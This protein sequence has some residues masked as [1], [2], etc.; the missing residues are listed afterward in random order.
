MLAETGQLLQ[1]NDARGRQGVMPNFTCTNPILQTLILDL[2]PRSRG[3]AILEE[4]DRNGNGAF[5]RP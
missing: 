4:Q 1:Y 2:G 5:A 3:G